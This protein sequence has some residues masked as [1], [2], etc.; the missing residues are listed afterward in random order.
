V[1]S[2]LERIR[3]VEKITEALA[4]RQEKERYLDFVRKLSGIPIIISDAPCIFT[5]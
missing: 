4:L 3:D 5:M 2:E 1:Y